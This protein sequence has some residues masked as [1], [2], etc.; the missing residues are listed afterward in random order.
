MKWYQKTAI[1][2]GSGFLLG[3]QTLNML[4]VMLTE[5]SIQRMLPHVAIWLLMLVLFIPFIVKSK[6]WY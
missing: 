3:V 4:R 5:P 6:T 1:L 2:F